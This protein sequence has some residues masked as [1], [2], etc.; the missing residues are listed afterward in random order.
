M[1]TIVP[2]D[3][4]KMLETV[5]ING[6][7]F[8]YKFK[9]A[10]KGQVPIRIMPTIADVIMWLYKVDK[11]WIYARSDGYGLEE[12]KFEYVIHHNDKGWSQIRQ[13]GER[14]DL[15]YK[16]P[17]KALIEGIKYMLINESL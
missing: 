5:K 17:K 16:S 3:I 15:W 13:S 4:K 1:N 10:C 9:P 11:I 14:L 2:S 8:D 12:L 6:K 7:G